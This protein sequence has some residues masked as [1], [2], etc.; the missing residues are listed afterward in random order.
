MSARLP[1]AVHSLTALVALALAALA[2]AALA[3]CST[4]VRV[5]EVPRITDC[6][7]ARI[8]AEGD[9]CTLPEPCLWS[10]P[11]ADGGCCTTRATCRGGRL[12]LD[13]GCG[14]A[15]RDCGREADCPFGIAFCLGN[16]CAP[17]PDTE[18]CAPCPTGW[19]PLERNGCPSC[20]CAPPS[21]CDV[22]APGTCPSPNRCYI[23]AFCAEGCDSIDC[24]VNVCSGADCIPLV[25]EGCPVPCSA[26]PGCSQC[27]LEQC[28]CTPGGQWAC[29]E[30]CVAPGSV[31]ECRFPPHDV[32]IVP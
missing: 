15:C 23:G 25:F 31:R 11:A 17:C 24:C 13:V 29:R 12:S 32:V 30:R 8:G 18:P 7:L 6:D 27:A 21:Q 10:E 9:A 1:R 4:P 14:Q 19:V 16:Q 22:F 3:T 5:L 20:E 2:L 26:T 28:T